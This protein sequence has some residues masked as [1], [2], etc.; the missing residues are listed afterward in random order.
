MRAEELMPGHSY[1]YTM[2]VPHEPVRAEVLAP[3]D[4]GQVRVKLHF[5]DGDSEECTLATRD[6]ANGWDEEPDDRF[7]KSGQPINRMLIEARAE[8]H[9]HTWSSLMEMTHQT[10]LVQRAQADRLAR[11]GI[12]RGH[13]HYAGRG[14][15]GHMNDPRVQTVLNPAELEQLLIAAEGGPATHVVDVDAVHR[16]AQ[17][18]S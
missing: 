3:A 6:I 5:P 18:R 8:G 15:S 13:A 4:S 10:V 17:A 11:F 7:F 14:G 16:D 12:H 1:A 9:V 2:T